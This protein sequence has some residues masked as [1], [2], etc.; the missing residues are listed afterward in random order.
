MLVPES[1][2]I[3]TQRLRVVPFSE[4]YLTSRYVGWLNDP[5]VVRYSDQRFRR[6]TIESCRR[7][8]RETE[9]SPS[10]F[11]AI[12]AKDEKLGHIG[13]ISAY[14]DREH[15]VADLA[16]MVGQREVWAQGY[17]SEAWVAACDYLL[18]DGGLRKVTA[19]T[20]AANSAM[21][22]VMRRAGMV[23]DGRRVRQRLFEGNE[24]DLVHTAL[25]QDNAPH[26]AGVERQ[27]A[28]GEVQYG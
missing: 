16:I 18:R 10:H 5:E 19:G 24:V 26:A 2:S 27:L 6:H 14:V 22:G 23:P 11:W 7:Y 3:E 15:L 12:V 9:G 17:G 20:L 8:W 1:P 25:F 21:L 4:Q 28:G 13:N